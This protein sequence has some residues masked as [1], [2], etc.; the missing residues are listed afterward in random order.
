[1]A[2]HTVADYTVIYAGSFLLSQDIDSDG[3]N[4]RWKDFN[5][6]LPSNLV[7]GEDK[8][9]LILQFEV[10]P[11]ERSHMDIFMNNNV[12]SDAGYNKSN[13]RMCQVIFPFSAAVPERCIKPNYP[14]RFKIDGGRMRVKNIVL[15]YQLYV[16][17]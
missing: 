1:M 11:S 13:T 15:W 8:A 12:I 4:R 6:K 10:E 17:D 14:L 7:L 9:R 5:F 16:E 3:V 2:K